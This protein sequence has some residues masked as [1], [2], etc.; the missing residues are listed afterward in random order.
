MDR[1]DRHRETDAIGRCHFTAAPQVGQSKAALGRNQCNICGSQC[2]IANVI[3]V[4]PRQTVTLEG[5]NVAANQRFRPGIASFCHQHGTNA[6]ME[7]GSA[8]RTL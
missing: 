6:D 3:L 8:S 5:R 1:A 4:R 2:V 7:I